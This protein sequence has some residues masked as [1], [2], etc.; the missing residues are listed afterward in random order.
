MLQ[1]GTPYEGQS[2]G[3]GQILRWLKEDVWQKL[4]KTSTKMDT[5][6]LLDSTILHEVRKQ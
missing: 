6:S 1:R 4:P 2:S 3:K 5:W